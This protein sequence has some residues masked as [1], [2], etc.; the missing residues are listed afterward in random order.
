MQSARRLLHLRQAV[1]HSPSFP[2]SG[3][4]GPLMT[5]ALTSFH[6]HFVAILKLAE[7]E[8]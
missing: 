3:A 7:V 1:R 8:A 5:F 6:S 2:G 4:F